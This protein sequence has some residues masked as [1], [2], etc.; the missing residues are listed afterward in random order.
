MIKRS[1]MLHSVTMARRNF[2]A[3]AMLS[4]TIILS[5]ALLLGYFAYSDSTLYNT[6]KKTF[7]LDRQL[8]SIWEESM[9][10]GRY[11]ALMEQT[12]KIPET[13]SYSV[14]MP[15]SVEFVFANLTDPQGR[16]AYIPNV[17]VICIP[18]QIWELYNM[19]LE[20]YEITWLDHQARNGIELASGEALLDAYTFRLLGLDQMEDPVYTFQ[21]S[22]FHS[23]SLVPVTVRIVGTFLQSEEFATQVDDAGEGVVAAEY[24]P[25][26]IFSLMDLNPQVA[27]E[28]KW[29]RRVVFHTQ[30]PEQLYEVTENMDFDGNAIYVRQNSALAAMRQ[31]KQIKA[32]IAA[33]LL[34][35]LGFNLYSS[36]NNALSERKFEI[37]VKRALGASKWSIVRQFLYESI[38]V[39]LI[40]ILLSVALV[41]DAALIYKL[42]YESIPDKFGIYHEFILYLSPYSAAMFLICSVSLSVVFSIIFSYKS[43]QIQ[44]VDYLK[45]E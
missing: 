19:E 26:C 33:A 10:T 34:L 5:F 40:D 45:A 16:A 14:L 18:S 8:V 43:T 6:Y 2:R 38:L 9:P 44:I 32:V 7:S 17:G 35:L 29:A 1:V 13:H 3:Y 25:Q 30:D 21:V 12:A 11:D 39:M 22:S 4:V 23:S 42:V 28:F 24:A 31:Q 20:K 27:P 36:F 15:E 37:G 41:V